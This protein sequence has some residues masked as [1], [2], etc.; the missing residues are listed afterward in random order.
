[1]AVG[2]IIGTLVGVWMVMDKRQPVSQVL[3]GLS[4]AKQ[5]KLFNKVKAIIW[6][7]DSMN[8]EQLTECVMSSETLQQQLVELLEDFFEKELKI[9]HEKQR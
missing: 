5:Q 7:L 1:M 6:N 4:G 3:K 9:P 2:G 8:E